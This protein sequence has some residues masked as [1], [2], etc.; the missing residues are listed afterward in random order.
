MESYYKKHIDKYTPV[1]ASYAQE[2]SENYIPVMNERRYPSGKNIHMVDNYTIFHDTLVLKAQMNA[3][4]KKTTY[5][6][7]LAI[8]MI[9]YMNKIGNTLTNMKNFYTPYIDKSAKGLK[10]D[11]SEEEI[12]NRENMPDEDQIKNLKEMYCA[13][14]KESGK[15]EEKNDDFPTNLSDAKKKVRDKFAEFM[16]ELTQKVDL[17][18][19]DC[20]G[21]LP[22]QIL[23]TGYKE[24]NPLKTFNFNFKGLI[25]TTYQKKIEDWCN[26]PENNICEVLFLKGAWH[27]MTHCRQTDDEYKTET[28]AYLK[29]LQ[30]FKEP[31]LLETGFF[32][33]ANAAMDRIE[34]TRHDVKERGRIEQGSLNTNWTY[35]MIPLLNYLRDYAR[36]HFQDS[37]FLNMSD[38]QLMEE[39]KRISRDSSLRYS[40][41]TELEFRKALN[42]EYKD[43]VNTL[44]KE[45]KKDGAVRS[46]LQDAMTF[47]NSYRSG[48]KYQDIDEFLDDKK[49]LFEN[50]HEETSR[51][52]NETPSFSS[53][54]EEKFSL[55]QKDVLNYNKMYK[56]L[57]KIKPD[58]SIT[59]FC[60][61]IIDKNFEKK[62]EIEAAYNENGCL[63]FDEK[64]CKEDSEKINN[65]LN[66]CQHADKIALQIIQLQ[67]KQKKQVPFLSTFSK[68]GNPCP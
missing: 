38:A 60:E 49:Y 61:M 39:A 1:F 48:N 10:E 41:E 67:E 17:F 51:R 62:A 15:K 11:S 5:D 52:E 24:S 27:E 2:G 21:N 18:N 26:Q 22:V 19:T 30:K 68:K 40:R 33:R 37:N 7:A 42:V 58:A 32:G 23:K 47:Y 50:E 9:K 8:I 46:I 64:R 56:E 6:Q 65:I 28:F 55:S 44:K 66:H 43:L 34:A 36:N 13:I 3:L 14:L 12:K 59:D 25:G 57:R 31:P 20:K 35:Q 63:F 54:S 53:K 29:M 16:F 45:A 4:G